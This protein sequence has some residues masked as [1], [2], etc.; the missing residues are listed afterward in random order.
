[1]INY[2]TKNNLSFAHLNDETTHRF[3][4]T[5]IKLKSDTHYRTIVLDAAY[6]GVKEE[7]Q[8]IMNDTRHMSFTTDIM[9]N[10]KGSLMA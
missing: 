2:I 4:V 7:V 1:V 5:K 9:S 10:Q 6:A 3:A 8:K